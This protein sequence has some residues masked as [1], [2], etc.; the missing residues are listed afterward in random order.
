MARTIK[1]VLARRL[2]ILFLN[3][4]SAIEGA[5]EVAEI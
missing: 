1:D 5:P 2:C 4:R 3:A